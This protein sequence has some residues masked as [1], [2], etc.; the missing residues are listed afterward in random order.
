MSVASRAIRQAI[1]AAPRVA[2]KPSTAARSYSLLARAATATAT[3]S[4]FAKTQVDPVS[5]IVRQ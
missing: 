3:R 4:T 1:R 5:P 2:A